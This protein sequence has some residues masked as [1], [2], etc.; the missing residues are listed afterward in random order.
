VLIPRLLSVVP[1]SLPGAA[2]E[3]MGEIAYFGPE[4]RSA[5]GLRIA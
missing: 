4:I 3:S 2:T 5:A 1:L